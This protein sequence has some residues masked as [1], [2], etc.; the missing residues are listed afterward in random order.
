MLYSG[1]SQKRFDLTLT[2]TGLCS[3]TNDHLR[4]D[5]QVRPF[6]GANS[7]YYSLRLKL[8]SGAAPGT[9]FDGQALATNARFHA[10]VRDRSGSDVLSG[11]A[12]FAIG[13]LEVK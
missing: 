8:T 4:G 13:K 12:D 5:V 2:C 6:P 1:I 10:A 9:V 3:G 11:T 7:L